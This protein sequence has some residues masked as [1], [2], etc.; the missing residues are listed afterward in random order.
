MDGQNQWVHNWQ[1]KK[2]KNNSS[3]NL[4]AHGGKSVSTSSKI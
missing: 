4:L 3:A 2:K 1:T